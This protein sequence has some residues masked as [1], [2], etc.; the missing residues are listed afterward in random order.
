MIGGKGGKGGNDEVEE[1]SKNQEPEQ[2]LATRILPTLGVSVQNF[3]HCRSVRRKERISTLDMK[4]GEGTP[5]SYLSNYHWT[6]DK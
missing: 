3:D 6:F 2:K 4:R 5:F 1:V